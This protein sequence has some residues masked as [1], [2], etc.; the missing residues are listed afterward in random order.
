MSKDRPTEQG[1]SAAKKRIGIFGGSFNPVHIAHVALA[2]YLC[3]TSGL[4]EIWLTLSPL[5]PI[6]DHPE[7]LI[8]DRHRLA[9]LQIGCESSDKL[10]PCAIELDMPRPSYTIDT[11]RKLSTMHPD[12][13]FT[14]IIGSDNWA[15]FDRWREGE[16]IIRD[17]GVIVYPRPGYQIAT[18]RLPDGVRVAAT[19]LL[20]VS[21]TF[22][23]QGIAMGIDMNVF[24]PRGVY[25]YIRNNDLYRSQDNEH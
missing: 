4:D 18:D 14:L 25:Q 6:K 24:M 1:D 8:D 16:A 20:D 11:L 23:R 3:R 15:I 5:N 2:D 7:E 9:M 13:S 12:C 22:I 10:R 19:P 17:F 21:S